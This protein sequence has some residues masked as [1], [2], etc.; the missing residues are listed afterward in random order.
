MF[1]DIGY[2]CFPELDENDAIN[3]SA[4]FSEAIIRESFSLSLLLTLFNVSALFVLVVEVMVR[5]LW[6]DP[7]GFL[8]ETIPRL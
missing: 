5:L 1:A 8:R 4:F 6:F 7:V 2:F 3:S